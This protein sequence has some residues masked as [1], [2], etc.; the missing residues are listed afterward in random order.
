[1]AACSITAN[2][3]RLLTYFGTGC[4]QALQLETH[5]LQRTSCACA[6]V[7]AC[8]GTVVT[9]RPNQEQRGKGNEAKPASREKVEV[10]PICD[11]LVSR[12]V[13]LSLVSELADAAL[14]RLHLVFEVVRIKL[15]ED[16]F[17]LILVDSSEVL[18]VLGG[19][20]FGGFTLL[21]AW[22][23]GIRPSTISTR[24]TALR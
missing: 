16:L 24:S 10:Q 20:C 19:L 22:L 13:N 9:K 1:M 23:G 6:Q 7:A 11:Q 3:A 5:L 8:E 12:S 14:P 21:G 4:N 18:G 17:P 15:L 2:V